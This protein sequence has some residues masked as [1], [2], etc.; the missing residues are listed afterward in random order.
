MSRKGLQN[1]CDTGISAPRRDQ[2]VAGAVDRRAFNSTW[3]FCAVDQT[4]AI[5]PTV[6]TVSTMQRFCDT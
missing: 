5:A 3:R 4:L 1:R 2:K 6:S